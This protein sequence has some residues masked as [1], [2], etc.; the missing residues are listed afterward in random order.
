MIVSL[1][2]NEHIVTALCNEA[3]VNGVSRDFSRYMNRDRSFFTVHE[4]ENRAGIIVQGFIPVH[5]TEFFS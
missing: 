2:G 4:T 3:S 1:A 5:E